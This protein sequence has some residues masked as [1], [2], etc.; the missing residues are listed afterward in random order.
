[1]DDVARS[2]SLVPTER[3]LRPIGR[4]PS[5]PTYLRQLWKHRHFTVRQAWYRSLA[6]GRGTLLGRIWLVL[7]PFLNIFVYFLIF[8]LIL[9]TDRGID[10]FIAYLA[11]G[12]VM[13][14]PMRSALSVGSNL[15]AAN[16]SLMR[17][18]AF[19]R[20]TL[21]FAE[22][23]KSVI[24]FIPDLIAL[25][26][27]ILVI[28]PH[29][30][31]GWTWILLPIV[32]FFRTLFTTGL[33]LITARIN[34]FLPDLKLLWPIL[35]R[36]WFFASGVIFSVEHLVTNPTLQSILMANPAYVVVDTS[37]TAVL[38]KQVPPPSDWVQLAGWGVFTLLVGLV[39]FWRKEVEYNRVR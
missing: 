16:R 35:G 15:I 29:V 5:L 24:D 7:T 13:F 32:V 10:N 31:P 12:L 37:R 18:F 3:E 39:I 30:T 27:F 4:R 23:V 22:S 19:P 21:A 26:I 17:G 2:E 14:G 33:M 1:M 6:G 36:F 38:D 34:L 25:A 8:G 20:A 11:I 9:K 28:P